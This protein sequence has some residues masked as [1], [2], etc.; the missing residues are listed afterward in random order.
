MS[1]WTASELNKIGRAEELEIASRLRD[2]TLTRPVIV[3]VVRTGDDIFVRSAVKFSRAAWYR[4]TRETH[5]GHVSAAGVKK[6]VTFVDA[7]RE[8]PD[9]VD[10]A[11]WK[12]YGK[13]S[14]S[15]VDPCVGP[16]ARATTIKLVPG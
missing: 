13:Y 16:E 11:Y 2:G 8:H 5:S 4:A 14:K 7:P 12:K 6:D 10:A 1:G 9:D 3:W 15:I